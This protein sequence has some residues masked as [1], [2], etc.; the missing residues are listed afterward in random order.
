MEDTLELFQGIMK[1]GTWSRKYCVLRDNVLTYCDKQGGQIEGKI[2]LKIA[3]INELDA[4]K[5]EFLIDTGT[6]PLLFRAPNLA[7]KAKWVNAM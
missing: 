3:K 5:A 7:A 6:T 4:L 2:H 1:I